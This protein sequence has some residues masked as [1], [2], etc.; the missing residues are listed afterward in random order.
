M[1]MAIVRKCDFEGMKILPF[2]S[3]LGALAIS[4][5]CQA[6][7]PAATNQTTSG[8][9]IF[10]GWYA[11]PEGE[12]FGNQYWVYP[13]YSAKYGEQVFFDAFSSPDLVHWTKHGKVLDTNSVTWARRAMWAPSVIEKD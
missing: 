4:A 9:P 13:T 7:S 8:N 3:A 12:V 1:V 6:A 10:Q 5:S 11:D 2:Y